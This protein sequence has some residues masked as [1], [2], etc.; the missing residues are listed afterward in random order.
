MEFDTNLDYMT[1]T[2][3]CV[4]EWR[5]SVTNLLH[6]IELS[7]KRRPWRF[8]QYAGYTVTEKDGHVSW[9]QSARG[10]IV[11]ASGIIAA[12]MAQEADNWLPQQYRVTRLDFAVT[13]LLGEPQGIVS[14]LLENRREDWRFIL[15]HVTKGGGTL[16]VGNRTSDR[17]GRVYDKG[18]ELN[19]DLSEADQVPVNRL[20]RAEVEYKAKAARAAY[21]LWRS[22][23]T[24]DDRRQFICETVLTWFQER[25][26][27]LPVICTSPSVV[28]VA[29]RASDEVRT[30]RWFHEQVRPAIWRLVEGGMS[31]E[32]E[33]ALSLKTHSLSMADLVMVGDSALQFSFFDNSGVS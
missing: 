18:A 2:T 26:V 16:Y 24:T 21:D 5:Q 22:K 25:G 17:F 19:T 15:P 10:G 20:W 31:A 3:G 32:V 1:V 6:T 28:S 12:R 27:F 33:Q 14:S 13:F 30:L 11:Q 7:K 23:A 9:G 4:G 8:L 29:S